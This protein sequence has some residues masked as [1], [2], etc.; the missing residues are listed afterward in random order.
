[1]KAGPSGIAHP[2]SSGSG[3]VRG[4]R[5]KLNWLLAFIPVAILL[6]WYGASPIVVFGTSALALV[7][8]AA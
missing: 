4:H 7:P 8:L 6:R 1:M 2:P 5:M 3:S